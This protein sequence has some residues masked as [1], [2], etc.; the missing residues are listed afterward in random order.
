MAIRK[1]NRALLIFV[2]VILIVLGYT[3]MRENKLSSKAKAPSTAESTQA[4]PSAPASSAATA[5]TPTSG[6]ED[7]DSKISERQ[8]AFAQVIGDLADCFG[9]KI[10][11]PNSSAPVSLDT[12]IMDFQTALGPV[13]H[14]EDRWMD[15]HLRGVDGSEK[16]LRLEISENDD[17][18]IRKELHTEVIGRNGESV[19]V[20][21]DPAQAVNPSDQTLNELLRG[22]DVFSKEQAGSVFFPGGEHLDYIRKNDELS[23]IEFIKGDKFFQCDDLSH[24]EQC[25]CIR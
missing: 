15:W 19:V 12:I 17:G 6:N 22:G 1:Q 2:A 23:Q 18:S 24:R 4:L 16:R 20:E 21:M 11:E 9:Y 7:A 25:E 3:L 14:Q 5:A 13:T 10:A 8:K